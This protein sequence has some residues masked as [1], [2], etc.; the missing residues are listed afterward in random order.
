MGAYS[1][2]ADDVCRQRFP[3]TL[4][5]WLSWMTIRPL[6]LKQGAC[7]GRQTIP[8]HSSRSVR[9]SDDEW[10]LWRSR[11]RPAQQYWQG[12]SACRLRRAGQASA[13]SS[14]AWRCSVGR[15][16]PARRTWRRRAGNSDP[17]GHGPQRC[18]AL[19]SRIGR[20]SPGRCR[21][22]RGALRRCTRH[23]GD[24]DHCCRGQSHHRI[25]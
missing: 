22:R 10:S 9:H 25:A 15:R 21:V 3:I 13:R 4:R 5:H 18:H 11:D 20:G 12:T 8:S 2:E 23:Y 19:R 17:G 1:T 6:R 24:G 14:R 7:Q 16:R